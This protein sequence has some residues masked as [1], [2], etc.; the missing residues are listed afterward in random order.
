MADKVKS[1]K[2]KYLDLLEQA[3]GV[4][5]SKTGVNLSTDEIESLFTDLTNT[6]A[7]KVPH[8]LITLIFPKR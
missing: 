7:S 6:D 3:Y 1:K 4:A 5:G 2:D 8:A